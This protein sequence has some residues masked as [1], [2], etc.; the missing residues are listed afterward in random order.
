MTQDH[1]A[2]APQTG[3]SQAEPEV[4]ALRASIPCA[5]DVPPVWRCAVSDTIAAVDAAFCRPLQ[6]SRKKAERELGNRLDRILQ[7]IFDESRKHSPRSYRDACAI[8]RS[9]IASGIA[10]QSDETPQAAQPEGQEPGP[11]GDAQPSE[12][13]S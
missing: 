2:S 4:S 8:M 10:A 11:S 1:G 3:L 13:S 5:D 12:Q 9:L 7:G 6:Q